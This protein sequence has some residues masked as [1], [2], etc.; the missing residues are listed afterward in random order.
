MLA[1][2]ALG[3][4][5]EVEARTVE[6][7][8]EMCAECRAEL[9][10]W[11]ATAGALA[12]SAVPTEPPPALRSRILESVRASDAA[13]SSKIAGKVKEAASSNVIA[14]PRRVWGRGQALGAIAASLAVIALI[15]SLF[16]AWRL[17][18]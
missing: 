3:A 18:E 5:D 17:Y 2:H 14:M 12:Y 16:L 11:R 9:E 8:L 6:E 10:E 13:S 1:A 15:A 7:H 4:L